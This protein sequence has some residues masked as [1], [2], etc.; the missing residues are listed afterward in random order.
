MVFSRVG[1]VITLYCRNDITAET[2]SVLG[3]DSVR[4]WVNR[5][6]GNRPHGFEPDLQ[7]RA[8]VNLVREETQAS[9]LLTPDLE[10]FYTCGVM[11]MS[12]QAVTESL[13]LPLISKRTC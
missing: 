9:F 4:F 6:T 12:G 2:L 13:P 1:D 3:D 10:G 5:S 11:P 7:E 8:D